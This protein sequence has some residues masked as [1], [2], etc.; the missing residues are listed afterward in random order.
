MKKVF[1]NTLV[2]LGLLA[3]TGEI[4]PRCGIKVEEKVF[5]K[6]L[7]IMQ[8]IIAGEL[9]VGA[10]ASE[11]AISG[12]A[13]GAPVFVVAGFATGGARLVAQQG[14]NIANVPQLK[15][16]RLPARL[17]QPWRRPAHDVPARDPAGRRAL[18][19]V[20]CADRHRH[21]LHR[22]HRLR[23]D[24]GEQRPRFPHPGSAR[25]FWSDKIIAGMITIGMLG[26]AI[27][28]GMNRLN[29]YLLRWHRGLE[30]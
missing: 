20:G 9:D 4:A 19:P 22:R 27:D 7:D 25:V 21:R 30:H 14:L 17:A 18:H 2:A 23:D 29:N 24:R 8:A 3:A 26:L 13:G 10:T 28:I 6:G 5:A 16:K 1:G 12:R 15:G 11:A